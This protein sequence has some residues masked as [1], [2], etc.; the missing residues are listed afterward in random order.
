VRHGRHACPCWDH[1]TAV[2]DC[3]D[4]EVT[5]SEF[6]LRVARRTP[7]APSRKRVWNGSGTLRSD[8]VTWQCAATISGVLSLGY[9]RFPMYYGLIFQS[10][11]FCEACR[12]Y[13]LRQELIT[14]YAP[15]QNGI[16]E[17]FFRSLKEKC[18]WQHNFDDFAEARTATSK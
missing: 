8:G 12:D 17:R 14:P 9:D 13:R 18:V 2:I 16:G 1:L 6:S 10:R 7:S 4:R 11:R 3:H 15:E 5:G